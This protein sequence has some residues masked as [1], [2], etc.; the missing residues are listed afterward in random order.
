M[1]NVSK[2]PSQNA[3]KDRTTA[4]PA[5]SVLETVR[6]Q[7]DRRWQE[8]IYSISPAHASDPRFRDTLRL[9]YIGGAMAVFL[10]ES[11]KLTCT[12]IGELTGGW[13]AEM[14]E[15]GRKAGL[16]WKDLK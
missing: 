11:G 13:M 10:A 5:P 6:N 4:P 14:R 2:N 8:L 12:E 15:I 7:F 16:S 9:V 3:C 1:S